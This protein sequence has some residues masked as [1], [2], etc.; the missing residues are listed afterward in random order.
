M[1]LICSPGVH[2][3]EMIDEDFIDPFSQNSKE[4]L[5]ETDADFSTNRVPAKWA[6]ESMV[7]IGY[8]KHILFDKK[9]V[10]C[11]AEGKPGVAGKNG[12]N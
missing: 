8:R 6:N 10:A 7:M 1:V 12:K 5:S 11:S 2:A 9:E 4:V 3:Q